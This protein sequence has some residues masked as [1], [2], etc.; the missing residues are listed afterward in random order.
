MQFLCQHRQ[1]GRWSF[2]ARPDWRVTRQLLSVRSTFSPYLYRFSTVSISGAF[3][4]TCLGNFGS[5]AIVEIALL[6]G[7]AGPW[8]MAAMPATMHRPRG[9]LAVCALLMLL[10]G[11]VY[12]RAVAPAVQF[13]RHASAR[14]NDHAAVCQRPHHRATTSVHG[15]RGG[16]GER[17]HGARPRCRPTIGHRRRLHP[18]SH[19]PQPRH[20]AGKARLLPRPSQAASRALRCLSRRAC[21]PRHRR[22]HPP[23]AKRGRSFLAPPPTEATPRTQTAQAAAA[24]DL[25]S[26]EQRLRN[27][28]PHRHLHEALAEE[29]G[30]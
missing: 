15:A 10:G 18:R 21:R 30:R 1:H 5:A 9:S 16:R 13:R 17:C 26:L 29:P 4:L 25:A 12:H 11:C 19:H 8:R 27:T 6:T 20:R 28:H 22:S 23:H 7:L 24:L 3:L 14:T 2:V